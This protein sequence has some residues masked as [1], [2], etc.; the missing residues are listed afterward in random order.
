MLE[1]TINKRTRNIQYFI[2]IMFWQQGGDK[3]R[4]SL[5]PLIFCS[6]FD[7]IVPIKG[8]DPVSPPVDLNHRRL[9][10]CLNLAH[11]MDR[12]V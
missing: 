1:T 6:P 10:F 8:V 11:F 7:Y 9:L 5:V 4:G 12:Q 3:S 2:Q